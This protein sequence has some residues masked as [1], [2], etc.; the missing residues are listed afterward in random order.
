MTPESNSSQLFPRV[1]FR[2]RVR[3]LPLLMGILLGIGGLLLGQQFG[4]IIPSRTAAI[5]MIIGGPLLGLVLANAGRAI[6]FSRMNRQIAQA[7]ASLPADS[8]AAELASIGWAPTHRVPASG[9]RAW[10]EPD[11]STSETPLD[12]G[13]ELQV[14]EQRG[15]WARVAASNGWEGWVDARNLEPV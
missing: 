1:K 14:V 8:A 9:V 11:P 10:A 7:E 4:V 5:Y 13:V 2:P 15:D 3:V 12:G 6:A